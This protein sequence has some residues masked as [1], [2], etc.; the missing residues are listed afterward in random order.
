MNV[1]RWEGPQARSDVFATEWQPVADQL[2]ERPQQWAVVY[3]GGASEANNIATK[4]KTGRSPFDPRG[5]Y[6]AATRTVRTRGDRDV[7]VYARYMGG[8]S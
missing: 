8:A 7:L 1:I 4:I 3:E 5:H 2:R 6:H